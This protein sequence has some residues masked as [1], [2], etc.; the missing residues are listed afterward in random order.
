MLV[1]SSVWVAL[2]LAPHA[3]HAVAREWFESIGE[4]QSVL[5][6]RSTQQTF[7]RLMTNAV[8]F[9]AYEHA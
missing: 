5:F 4:P 1:D 9:A 6:C 8:V 3:H 2:A 7:L